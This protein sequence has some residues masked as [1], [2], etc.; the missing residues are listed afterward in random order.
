MNIQT[1][2]IGIVIGLVL[3]AGVG[4]G[5]TS[6]QLSELQ[7]QINLIKLEADKV[8]NLQQ[9]I[10]TL[11]NEKSSLQTQISEL[12]SQISSLSSNNSNLESQIN[13]LQTQILSKNNEITSLQKQVSSK[14]PT[15]VSTSFSRTQD[16]AYLLQQ[17]IRKAN[18][19]IKLMLYL[20]TQD[21]LAESLISA[22]NRG[23][24][25]DAIIDDE[26]ISA[27]GSDFQTLLNSG[28]DIRSD[29][30]AG[31]MH[32]KIMIIDDYIIVTGSY[33]WSNT[34]EDSNDENII[35]LKSESISS[36]YL[37]EFNRIWSQTNQSIPQPSPTPTPS[38]SPP[39][40]YNGPFWA[41]KKSNIY[42]LPTCYWAQ[43]ISADNLIIFNTRSEAEAAGYRAC[44]V[45]QP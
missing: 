2:T 31:T 7:N 25:I 1:I 29:N 23:I 44:Y 5:V 6:Y 32:H 35:I 43:Q 36:L 18:Y 22:K 40:S 39:P 45:C 17:W 15:F 3:G 12:Q 4:Y 34:A 16:T 30:R 42:H 41:S 33:N 10:T 26:W 19:T 38:P 13:S 9:Q 21:S 24:D 27:S 20:I 37:S 28:I 11:S 14:D 8:P